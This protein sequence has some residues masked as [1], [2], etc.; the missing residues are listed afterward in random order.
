MTKLWLGV[1]SIALSFL[2]SPTLHAQTS[3]FGA[4]WKLES[5]ASSLKFQSIKNQ[6]KIETSSFAS[7]TGAID[8]DGQ[9]A[10]KILLDSVDTKVDLRNVRMRFLFFETFQYPEANVTARIDPA[11]A[12]DL[13]TLRRKTVTLPFTLDL[14]GVTK[15]LEAEL[16]LTLIGDDLIAVSTAEPIN[17]A[18]ADFNLMEGLKKLEEAANVTVVPSTSVSFDFIFRA[19]EDADTI[20]QLAANEPV[21]EPASAALEAEGDF[22]LEAC[23]GRFEILSRSGNIYFQPGSARLDSAST[24]LLDTVADIVSRCPGLEIQVAGHT[25]SVGADAANQRLSERRAASVVSFLTSRGIDASRMR[26]LGFGED[27]P[28]ADNTTKEGRSRNRRIEFS[29]AG[30]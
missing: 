2:F 15:S 11:L 30:T 9:A 4:G 6:S 13:A 25:D 16:S 27:R 20:Q 22:S 5:E 18:V 28:V 17:I 26:S 12:S 8:P 14:H 23:V 3:P 29:V 10:V 24:P 1:A 19:S 21:A 7:I